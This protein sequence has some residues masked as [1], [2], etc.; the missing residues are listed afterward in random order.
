MPDAVLKT[1]RV[2]ARDNETF[3]ECTVAA[4]L[5]LTVVGTVKHP[6]D[7]E[8]IRAERAVRTY[9]DVLQILRACGGPVN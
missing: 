2:V 6:P 7:D 3:C 9:K 5:T 8:L 1:L 4:I